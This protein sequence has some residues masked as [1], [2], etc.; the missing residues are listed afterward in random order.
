MDMPSID[1]YESI[2]KYI[3]RI[4]TIT[5][6]YHLEISEPK[7]A[8]C[9]L[10]RIINLFPELNSIEIH[11]LSYERSKYLDSEEIGRIYSTFNTKKLTKLYVREMILNDETFFLLTFF[12]CTVHLKIDFIYDMD[13]QSCLRSILKEIEHNGHHLRSLCYCVPLIDDEMIDT[14]EKMIDN[15]KLLGNFTIKRV[16]ENIYLQWN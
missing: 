13:I 15:E 3:K 4:L 14:L 16:L 7:T 11:S 5:P 10:I 6:I 9:L 2:I 12:R 8:I 1:S